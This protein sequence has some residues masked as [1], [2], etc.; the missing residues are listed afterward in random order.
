MTVQ[1]TE[2]WYRL[3]KCFHYLGYH[4]K[5]VMSYSFDN[6]LAYS[7]VTSNDVEVREIRSFFPRE[8]QPRR[9][10]AAI[11]VIEGLAD[12]GSTIYR[13][14]EVFH[15]RQI[16]R[17]DRSHYSGASRDFIYTL[18]GVGTSFGEGLV[19]NGLSWFDPFLKKNGNFGFGLDH[20]RDAEVKQHFLDLAR[21]FFR[22]PVA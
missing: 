11:W 20:L 12:R 16:T 6:A 2:D 14:R 8:G 17:A 7:L 18:D 3:L 13:L 4:T 22:K 5:E 10:D 21:P 19:L 9:Q 1:M 15:P